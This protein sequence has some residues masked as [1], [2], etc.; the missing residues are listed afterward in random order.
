[1]TRRGALLKVLAGFAR[2]WPWRLA[3]GVVLTAAALAMG[4][5][6][7]ASSGVLITGSALAG[8]G[9]IVFN[10]FTPSS[11]IRAL[12]LG[13]TLARYAERLATHDATLRFLADLRVA[14]FRRLIGS[15]TGTERPGLMFNRLTGDLDALDGVVI[16][17][18]VP[19]A[20]ATMVLSGSALVLSVIAWPLA[21]G[22]V[23][24]LT[25]GGIAVPLG[26][27]R[28]GARAARAKQH[29][30]DAMRV[31]IVDLDRDR[32]ALG[33]RGRMAAA[34]GGVEAAAD[35]AADA[36][37]RLARLDAVARI[38]SGLGHQGAVFAA[39]VLGAGLVADGTL[40][41]MGYTALV[42]FALALGETIAPFRSL[43]LEGG[44]W[45]LAA[46]RL[47]GEA[48]D[49]HA[50]PAALPPDDDR[51]VVLSDAGL[52][53]SAADVERLQATTV[54]IVRGETLALV[55]PSGGGKS[56]LM[57]LIA[58]RLAPT[59]GTVLHR[60]GL[61]IA[62]LGQRTE[63]FR[64]TVAEN[65]RLARPDAS[66]ETLLAAVRSVGLEAA[67]GPAGLA[68]PLGDGGSGLS[69]GERRRLAVARTLLLDADLYLFDE[70]TEGLDAATAA[71]V[72]S[73]IRARTA[74]AGLVIATHRPT[75]AAAATRRLVVEGGRVSASEPE[76]G[77]P[78]T[79][80]TAE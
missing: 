40:T 35:R 8:L 69:G 44:R 55:G 33:A 53:E 48:D 58:G 46:R 36:E 62:W 13:R 37:R 79:L 60:P 5:G 23:L 64:G 70:P 25:L 39:V 31:R 41:P 3:A 52:R 51:L 2:T 57:G 78:R 18:A 28:A 49:G 67:L 80:T 77:P 75:E 50:R 43:A 17:L 14:T 32:A 72:L 21:A 11:L 29:A 63:L 27:V 66:D 73:A 59:A 24:P 1:M 4:A 7:L 47:T 30:L 76:P 71:V 10:T 22:L 26:L 56:T 6:L 16:R 45:S 68:A 9:L 61:R 34:V 38:A 74:G 12:A 65:L 20:A 15:H 54:A 19:F 42:L